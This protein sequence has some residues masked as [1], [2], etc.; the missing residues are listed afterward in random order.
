MKKC[1]Q[2][3]DSDVYFFLFQLT[4]MCQNICSQFL[5]DLKTQNDPL[6]PGMKK[7]ID[8]IEY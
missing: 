7:N 2:N 8:L 5:K 3:C 6:E 1:L 4:L